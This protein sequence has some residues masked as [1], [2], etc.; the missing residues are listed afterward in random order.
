MSDE[1]TVKKSYIDQCEALA[2]A[3][4][5]DQMAIESKWISVDTSMPLEEGDDLC[6]WLTWSDDAGFL[7]AEY[8]QIRMGWY[9][10]GREIEDV[11]HWMPLPSIP[12]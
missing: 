8:D 11:T 6:E 7:V 10:D 5:A 1:I 3:V 2:R 4:M 12:K 9:A